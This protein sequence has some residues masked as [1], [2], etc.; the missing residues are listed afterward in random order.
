MNAYEIPDEKPKESDPIET[1]KELAKDVFDSRCQD[2]YK[3]PNELDDIFN[4]SNELSIKCVDGHVCSKEDVLSIVIYD[5]IVVFRGKEWEMGIPIN[6]ISE[7]YL[8][9]G[10]QCPKT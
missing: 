7:Y 5:N 3:S 2:V 1:L 8:K 9:K 6:Q 4:S 10:K